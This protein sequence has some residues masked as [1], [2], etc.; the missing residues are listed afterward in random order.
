[1]GGGLERRMVSW[2]G[3]WCCCADD[4]DVAVD[5]DCCDEDVGGYYISRAHYQM[6]MLCC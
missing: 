2:L 6:Y 5:D 3:L 4:E 1:V